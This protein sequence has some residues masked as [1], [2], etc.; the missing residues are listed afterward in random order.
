M[1][2]N[3][4]GNHAYADNAIQILN[5]YGQRLKGYS[6][7][8]PYSNEP[9]QA[10][11]DGQ[12]WPRAAEIIRYSG[13]GWNDSDIATFERMLR[14]AILPMVRNGSP[15]NGNW[16]I[17]MNETL[18]GIGVLT[19]DRDLFD[20]GV[21]HWRERTPAVFYLHTDGAGCGRSHGRLDRS[22]TKHHRA[23]ASIADG[24]RIHPLPRWFCIP[25]LQGIVV[26]SYRLGKPK[27]LCQRKGS[28]N[29]GRIKEKAAARE[30]THDYALS[31]YE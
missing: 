22:P 26:A 1:L 30:S 24:Q 28:S 10:A 14:T 4:T 31:S 7:E 27:P 13:A 29:S 16:E 20:A 18:I 2:W 3:I 21:Q 5:A 9:L 12:H 8:K 6:Q 11:W 23:Q 15:S 25:Q 19:N 17:S